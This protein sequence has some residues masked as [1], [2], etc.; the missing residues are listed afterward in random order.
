[1]GANL[2]TP[3]SQL[4]SPISH[5]G[6]LPRYLHHLQRACYRPGSGARA[7]GGRLRGAAATPANLLWAADDLER[8]AERGEGASDAAAGMAR[9]LRRGGYADHR[10]GAELHSDLPRRIPGSTGRPA[11]RRACQAVVSDRR[12]FGTRDREWEGEATFYGRRTNDE[13]PK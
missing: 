6:S 8:A 1:M 12:V 4:P 7:G 3:N 5:S 10:P 2:P 11:R 9:A 13:R